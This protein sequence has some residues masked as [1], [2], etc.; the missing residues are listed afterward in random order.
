V[1]VLITTRTKIR[2]IVLGYIINRKSGQKF[3]VD[4]NQLSL[5]MKHDYLKEENGFFYF[6]ESVKNK[7][8][9]MLKADMADKVNM[10]YGL[11]ELVQELHD[12][13]AKD[14]FESDSIKINHLFLKIRRLRRLY[15]TLVSEGF[16]KQD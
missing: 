16:E 7:I 11:K 6:E 3:K 12:Q 4:N 9:L 2:R 10:V 8:T 14:F 5:L 15:Q 1:T 13:S